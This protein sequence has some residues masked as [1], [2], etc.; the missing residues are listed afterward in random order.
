MLIPIFTPLGD[1]GSPPF[2]ILTGPDLP[3]PIIFLTPVLPPAFLLTTIRLSFSEI[4][5][6]AFLIIFLA[7]VA[8]LVFGRDFINK[9]SSLLEIVPLVLPIIF[10]IAFIC[11]CV[12]SFLSSALPPACIFFIP[13]RPAAIIFLL[14]FPLFILY[15]SPFFYKFIKNVF[16]PKFIIA[17]FFKLL[18]CFVK[19]IQGL[20]KNHYVRLI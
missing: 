19:F 3:P 12:N 11:S 5:L 9:S 14:F 8:L 20:Y 4:G 13:A 7:A 6:S 15:L 10:L 2:I 18:G 1:N 16:V 17:L